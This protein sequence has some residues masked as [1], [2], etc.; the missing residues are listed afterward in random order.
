MKSTPKYGLK[1]W[2]GSDRI[3]RTDFNDNNTAIEAALEEKQDS[4]DTLD[5]RITAHDAQFNAHDGRL[6]AHDTTLSSHTST[7]SSHTSTI[8]SHTSSISSLTTKTNTNATNITNLTKTVN[9]NYNSRVRILTGTYVGDHTSNRNIDLGEEVSLIIVYQ[10]GAT[11]TN[12]PSSL[13][14]IPP[15]GCSAGNNGGYHVARH[16]GTGFTISKMDDFNYNKNTYG[17]IAFVL[18]T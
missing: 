8:K 6:D 18:D 1:Q 3:L 16:T 2:E 9:A 13:I 17:Y 15:N 12:Y 4:L 10:I 7:L 5:S 11:F 14:F